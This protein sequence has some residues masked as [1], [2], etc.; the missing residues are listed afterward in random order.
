VLLVEDEEPLMLLAEEMLAALNFEP[1]GFTQA[2]DALAEFRVDPWR[3][4]LVIVDHLMPTT[5]GIDFAREVRRACP[6]ICIIL[7]SG[8]IGPLL[9]QD[10]TAAGVQRILTKPLDLEALGEDI[11]SLLT[12]VPAR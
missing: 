5:T 8:Y 6:D 1:A 9:T 2:N 4:D 10:A 11:G 7:L 12:H 3:F